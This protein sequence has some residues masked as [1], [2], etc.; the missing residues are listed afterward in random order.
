MLSIVHRS[1]GLRLTVAA[2]ALLASITPPAA[3]ATNV[4]GTSDIAYIQQSPAV[5]IATGFTASGGLTYDG[6]YMEVSVADQTT[7]ETLALKTVDSPDTTD[8]AISVVGT[9]I[10]LGDGSGA[11]VIA[12]I[13]GVR[14]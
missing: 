7:D 2:A 14:N 9:S 4:D 5:A 6:E 3:A 13:D 1:R 10:F 8:G 12:S 11:E